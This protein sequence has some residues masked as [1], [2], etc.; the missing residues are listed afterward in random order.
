MTPAMPA[1]LDPHLAAL[2]N[3]LQELFLPDALDVRPRQIP[4]KVAR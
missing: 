2:L 4:I 3:D 1:H